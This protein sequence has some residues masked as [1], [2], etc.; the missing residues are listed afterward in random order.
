MLRVS[1]TINT[2]PENGNMQFNITLCNSDSASDILESKEIFNAFVNGYG[3]L[4]GSILHTTSSNKSNMVP[5]EV[6]R[7][8]HYIVDIENTLEI[9]FDAEKDITLEDIKLV[10]ELHRCFI[11]KKPFKQYIND[12]TMRGAGDFDLSSLD[13]GNGPIGK[14]LLG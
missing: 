7:F 8:W 2:D 4:C 1:Y 14:E 6:L 3:N 12:S 5:E 9:K 13:G 10:N 11:E